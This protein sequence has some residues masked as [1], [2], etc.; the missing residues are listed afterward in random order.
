MKQLLETIF[1]GDGRFIFLEYEESIDI[2]NNLVKDM[3]I[4]SLE[5]IPYDQQWHFDAYLLK[6]PGVNKVLQN[7]DVIDWK[8][9]LLNYATSFPFTAQDL[10]NHISSLYKKF[11]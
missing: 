7:R 5:N 11:L 2:Q 8:L 9:N 10:N 3:I 1:V 6:V 4:I